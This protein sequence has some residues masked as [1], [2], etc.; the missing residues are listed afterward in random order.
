MSPSVYF[1]LT[2]PRYPTP[3]E[4][5]TKMGQA[6]RTIHAVC[7]EPFA[8]GFPEYGEG[9]VLGKKLRVYLE[10]AD[11]A[12][13]LADKLEKELSGP[14]Q[15]LVLGRNKKLTRAELQGPQVV[16][17]MK[18]LSSK[19]SASPDDENYS[20]RIE[21]QAKRRARQKVE[22]AALPFVWM[23]SSSGAKFKLVIDRAFVEHPME[24]E[25]NGYGLSRKSGMVSL[26]A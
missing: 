14:C 23:A 21:A 16:Y 11:A 18:R 19:S 3:G 4:L 26:P 8:M 17:M 20:K 24:G 6:W 22:Q 25:P 9:N 10:S 12:D 7:R 5:Y 13:D 2:F 1:D 15:G